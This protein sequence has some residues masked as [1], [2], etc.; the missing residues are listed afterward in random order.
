MVR[1]AI[2]SLIISTAALF[3]SSCCKEQEREVEITQS[4]K[5]GENSVPAV[6]PLPGGKANFSAV[7]GNMDIT[8]PLFSRFVI[9]HSTVLLAQCYSYWDRN[10]TAEKGKTLLNAHTCTSEGII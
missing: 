10:S 7:V 5:S 2:P 1:N 6:Q 3:F 9:I 4:L 8:A